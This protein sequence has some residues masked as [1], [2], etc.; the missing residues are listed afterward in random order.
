MI[1]YTDYFSPEACSNRINAALFDGDIN[2]QQ[3]DGVNT[4]FDVYFHLYQHN[5]DAPISYLAYTLATVFHETAKT[6]QPI[7]EYGKGKGHP[8]GEPDPITGQTYYG[9]GHTQNTWKTN[10]ETLSQYLFDKDSSRGVDV[11]SH[12]DL[13][14]EGFYSVQATLIGM[15]FGIYTGK[16]YSDYLDGQT[17]DYVNA[18]RIINGKD[19]A[20]LIAG[21]AV[22]FEKAIRIGMGQKVERSLVLVGSRGDDVRELQLMLDINADGSFGGD[23]KEAVI[24]FQKAN[25]L[26]ADGKVGS[27]TWSALERELYWSELYEK[28][29][30]FNN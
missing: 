21:Y 3:I 2:E 24:S 13:L 26:V 19:R 9:R 20:E 14:L 15:T 29:V 25:N 8:Y 27:K 10:Y 11:V 22:E 30:F 4:F 28:S 17:P 6:M 1:S 16:K 23:T 5:I 7:A 18:R 12:P